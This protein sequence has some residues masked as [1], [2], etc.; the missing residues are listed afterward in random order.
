[1]NHNHAMSQ[2]VLPS[3]DGSDQVVRKLI[4]NL[5]VNTPYNKQNEL[6][7]RKNVS[8]SIS[9]LEK[10]QHKSQ[11]NFHK[12]AKQHQGSKNSTIFDPNSENEN[13]ISLAK[14]QGINE[15]Q[16]RAGKPTP[17]VEKNVVDNF[18]RK[19]IMEA[20]LQRSKLGEMNNDLL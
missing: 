6:T 19:N 18:Y 14:S 15:D 5:G 20:K 17:K 4:Y 16:K 12:L 9:V 8:N 3:P 7:R 10:Y 11:N 13:F 2:M 1:M